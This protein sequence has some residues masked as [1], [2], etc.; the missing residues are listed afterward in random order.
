MLLFAFVGRFLCCG[1]MAGCLLCPTAVQ[2]FVFAA[3][4]VFRFALF[5]L[6]LVEHEHV[7]HLAHRGDVWLVSVQRCRD[8]HYLVLPH[9]PDGLTPGLFGE[10]PADVRPE[11]GQVLVDRDLFAVCAEPFALWRGVRA[12]LAKCGHGRESIAIP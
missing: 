2:V 10:L 9:V 11:A 4:E 1:L 12:G 7:F 8:P 5:A 3:C 6:L